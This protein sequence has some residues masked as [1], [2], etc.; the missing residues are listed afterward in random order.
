MKKIHLF[1]VALVAVF[2]MTGGAYAAGKYLITSTK[3]ISPKVL[4]VLKGKNG[5]NGANGINGKDGVQGP[6]GAQGPPGANG[7]IGTNGTNGESVASTPLAV[8]NKEC[9]EG[10][11]EFTAGGKHTYACTGSPWP[12]GGTLPSGRT[13]TGV[14]GVSALPGVVVPTSGEFAFSPISFTMPLKAGLSKA[15]VHVIAVGGEGTGGGCPP[16]SSVTKPEAEP[17]NLCIFQQLGLNILRVSALS[18]ETKEEEEAG[19]TGT[20]VQV[21]PE[22]SGKT[23]YVYGT[24]AVTAE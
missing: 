18:P 7:T 9:P 8:K 17:G 12:A 1:T 4:K 21:K 20:L 2:A 23:V 6:L 10:G 24:W 13:E 11:S 19:P 15:N 14:W 5:T 22:T 16:K 3:Q